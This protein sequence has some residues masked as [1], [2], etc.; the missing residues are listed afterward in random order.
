M[1]TDLNKLSYEIDNVLSKLLME[2]D[3]GPLEL[4]S[5]ILARLVRMNQEFSCHEDFNR[6]MEVASL[7]KPVARIYQ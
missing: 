4:S 5:V 1:K 6:I 3:M 7:K 2:T